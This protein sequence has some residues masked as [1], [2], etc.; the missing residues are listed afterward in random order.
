VTAPDVLAARR[1]L[2]DDDRRVE[3]TGTDR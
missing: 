2:E 3:R 1:G